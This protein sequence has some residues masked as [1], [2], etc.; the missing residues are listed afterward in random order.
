MILPIAAPNG[1]SSG[2]KGNPVS[3]VFSDVH[4]ILLNKLQVHSRA[5]CR[6]FSFLVWD[7]VMASV[8]DFANV[9]LR[10]LCYRFV[11]P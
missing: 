7:L 10:G 9:V 6:Y 4:N 3:V 1:G 11:W 8:R 2:I 5:E